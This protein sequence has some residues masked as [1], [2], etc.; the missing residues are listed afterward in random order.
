MFPRFVAALC[1]AGCTRATTEQPTEPTTDPVRPTVPVEVTLVELEATPAEPVVGDDVQVTVVLDDV[2]LQATPVALDSDAPAVLPLPDAITVQA[3]SMQASTTARATAAGEVTLTAGLDDAV[4][5][6][7]LTVAPAPVVP[8]LVEVSPADG[9]AATSTSVTL[10]GT[11][12]E[13]DVQVEVGS[14]K[15]S[16]TWISSELLDCELPANGGVAAS[17][18]VTV[19]GSGGSDTLVEGFTY[20]GVVA[21]PGASFFCNLQWPP[22]TVTKAG[23]ATEAIFGRVYV[24]GATDASSKAASSVIG[25]VG[26]GAVGSHPEQVNWAWSAMAP[27]PHWDFDVNDDEYQGVLMVS[28]AGAYDY[29]TRFSLDGGLTFTYCDG[30]GSDDGFD[31]KLAG[32]LTVK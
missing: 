31:P 3:G 29:A 14:T 2:A 18:D 19:V 22:T 11:D 26:T 12:F 20:T 4:E 10:R 5:S 23:V 32:Q 25:Q 16:C 15:A 27:N 8:V 30:N 6:V 21:D 13:E 9:L 7:Q 28:D 24:E 17:V 1:L